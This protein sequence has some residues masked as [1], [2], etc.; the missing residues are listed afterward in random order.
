[1]FI[2]KLTTDKVFSAT[3]LFTS[4]SLFFLIIFFSQCK[5]GLP[6]G[7]PDKGGLLLPGNFEAV[8]VVDSLGG[9]RHIAVNDNGDIYVKLRVAYPD[10]GNVALR[11]ENNDGKADVIK[12]FAV[13]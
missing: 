6:P 9:A 13:Y 12:K 1:M 4:L 5:N 8:V 10:G 3:K 7:D 2:K 11:D